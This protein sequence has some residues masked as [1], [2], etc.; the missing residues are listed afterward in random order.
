MNFTTKPQNPNGALK[1]L[2]NFLPYLWPQDQRALRLRV[3]FACCLL[4]LGKIINVFVP[5]LYKLCVDHLALNQTTVQ[6]WSV[7]VGLVA[8]YG[9]ARVSAQVFSELKDMLFAR[10]EQHAIRRSALQVFEHLHQLSLRF[11]LERKT[12]G[13]SR[14]IERGTKGIETL[15]RFMIFNI[16]PTF[17]EI[18]LVGVV[19]W[20]IYDQRYAWVTLGTLIAYVAYTL[21][22]TEWRTQLVRHM[23][24]VDGEA[25]AKAI[26]SLLNYETVKYF[27]NESYESQ[28]YNLSLGQYEKAALKSKYSLAYLNMGQGLIIALGL[29]AVMTMA[30]FDY[31]KG[32]MTLGDF[33][34]VNTYLLQLYMPLGVLGFAY[35]EIKLALVNMEAMFDLLGQDREVQDRADAKPLEVTGGEVRFENVSFHY[36][37]SRPILKGI[38]FVVPAGK[39]VAIV[40]SSGAGKSTLSRLLFRF[41]EVSDGRITIDGQDIRSVSQRSLREA[42]GIVPQDTV[43]FNDTIGYNI[44]YGRPSATQQEVEEAAQLAKIH[45]FIQKLPDGYDTTVGERGLK[46]SG[47]EKQRVA[48]ARTLLKKRKIFLFD[49]ATSALDTHTEKA[50]QQSLQEVSRAHTTLIIAHRLSTVVDA[51]EILVLEHGEIIERGTHKELLDKKGVYATLWQKQSKRVVAAGEA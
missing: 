23:N 13:L 41:Y 45:T 36:E 31:A 24:T 29:I 6:W 10:V 19:L 27:G 32:A 1:T 8:A 46:L 2:K 49:E 47:G 14:S 5:M 44:R 12:G 18:L 34:L 16:L 7:P 22:L 35:R 11:H 17:I 25:N 4:I 50:I 30:A 20:I 28:R 43:L 48:I 38:S 9:L 39:T 3:F 40:G 51:D 33:V 15:L 37:P 21:S 26:D 42:L